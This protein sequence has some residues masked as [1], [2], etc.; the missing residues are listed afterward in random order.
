MLLS[1]IFQGGLENYLVGGGGIELEGLGG[2]S[3]LCFTSG[4]LLDFCDI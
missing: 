3:F 4:F 2:C 1:N